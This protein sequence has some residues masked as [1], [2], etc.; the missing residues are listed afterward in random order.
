MSSHNQDAASDSLSLPTGSGL[1]VDVENLHSDAQ[2]LIQDLIREWPSSAPPLIRLSLYV[3]ADKVELWRLWVTSRYP[4]LAVVVS[5]TQHFSMSSSKNS[6]D[7]AIATNAIADLVL[8]RI[9][10]VAVF[11]D[12]SDFISLY[13]AIRDEPTI[14]SPEGKPPFLWIV[15]DRAGSLSSTVKH[16]FPWTSC[17]LLV[18]GR[19]LRTRLLLRPLR[20]IL[21]ARTSP[22]LQVFPGRKWRRRLSKTSQS[23]RSKAVIANP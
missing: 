16:F 11:S 17:M 7:L 5:G 9:G 23:G 4:D 15:T 1:Y 13:V 20:S 21:R 6:A 14:P 3:P 8:G 18:Q 19:C 22:P 10:H 2:I 12:D